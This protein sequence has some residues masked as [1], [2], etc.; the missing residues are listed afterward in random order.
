MAYLAEPLI[1]FFYSVEYLASV[2]VLGILASLIALNGLTTLLISLFNAQER[3][4]FY[5][6]VFAVAI[7]LNVILNYSLISQM[8]LIGAAYATV[9]TYAAILAVL[10]LEVRRNVGAVS[11][12]HIAKPLAASLVMFGLLQHVFPSAEWLPVSL[13]FAAAGFA[14]YLVV[15]LA[16]RGIT[17]AEVMHLK[18]RILN[19]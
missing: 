10:G 7:V 16:I 18:E 13:A 17:I 14:I 4:K 12:V 1:R 6:R 8:G 19:P 5:T 15:Q 9:L 11:L 3:P 2:E